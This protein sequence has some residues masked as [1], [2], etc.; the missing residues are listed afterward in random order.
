[1]KKKWYLSTFNPIRDLSIK[2]KFIILGLITLIPLL[3]LLW[4]N[5]QRLNAEIQ[6]NK[7]EREGIVYL[8]PIRDF[9]E[10][11]QAH[12]GMT[13]S[14]LSGDKSFAVKIDS[15]EQ[16]TDTLIGKI[17]QVNESLGAEFGT[18][19]NWGKIK[20]NWGNIK[21]QWL[22]LKSKSSL[23]TP[24]ESFKEHT[25][26]VNRLL[27]F[28]LQISDTSG[29]TLDPQ[30]D[31]YYVMDIVYL[32]SMNVIE[33]MA[34]IRGIGS[35]IASRNTVTPE[36]RM[37]LAVLSNQ[38]EASLKNFDHDMS[39]L[40]DFDG[41]YQKVNPVIDDLKHSILNLN[42]MVKTSIIDAKEIN[43]DASKYF[44]EA[45]KSIALGYKS[46]DELS[47]L[48][49]NL[50][51]DRLQAQ[52]YQL[53]KVLGLTIL[54]IIVVSCFLILIASHITNA[55]SQVKE[56]MNDLAQGEF[57]DSQ[58]VTV[59]SKDEMGQVIR[60]IASL[61]STLKHLIQ[62]L[63]YVSTQHE[64]GDI[65]V[66]IDVSR[67][68]GGYA[69]VAAGVNRMVAGHLDMSKKALA[70]VK[71][72]G[73]GDLD[74]KI[75]Q[76]PGKKAFVNE[77]I[78]QVRTN[79][80]ALVDDASLLAQA[81]V[82]GKLSTRADAS[83]HQGDFRKIVQ[84]VNDT[85]D[86]VITPLNVAAKY[87]EDISK[88]NIPAKITATYHGDFNTLKNNLNQCIDAVNALVADANVLANAA[89]QGQLSTRAD[90]SQHQGDF[91]KIVE[92][93]NNTLDSVVGPL[94]VAAECVAR[95]SQGDIPENISAHYHGD[96]NNIKNNLNT[97][98]NA[99]NRLVIDANMLAEA[100][101]EGRVT[102]RADATQHQGDFR[103]VVEGVNATLETIVQPI[104]VVKEAVEAITTA[105]GEISSGNSDLSA[106]TEQQAASLEETAASMEELASTVKQ[107]AENA[108]QANQLAMAA[109][110]VA[111]KGGDVVGQVVTT[112]ANINDSARKIEDII[113][114]IDGIAF[115]TNILALNAAV[116]AA[117]AGEQGR[118]FAVVAGEVRNLAQRSASAAKEIKELITDSVQKTTEGTTQVEN[119]GKT[120]DEIVNSVKRV[121]D[122]IG[123][124]AAASIEQSSGIDQV[125]TAVTNMD[126]V[127]QQNAALV[128]EAA[129]AA[130][131]LLEQ[132]NSLSETVSVFKLG[133]ESG[134]RGH[135]TSHSTHHHTSHTT[136]ERR[137][138]NS[139]LR[140]KTA[141]KA[142]AAPAPQAQATFAK[143][144]T[145][146][147]GDWEEF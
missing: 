101:S 55:A 28:M 52:K 144:G 95:I 132:A 27:E 33:N 16:K 147:A 75:E 53:Y 14:Y 76:F 106:R 22:Q 82:E 21:A 139:P 37:K 112:M 50:L 45:S 126:E 3:V 134:G 11:V 23:L 44:A 96:F 39:V 80:N 107:N 81:A 26:L 103:K 63:N 136:T 36:E 135:K 29:L 90:A 99:V 10:N 73:E 116:E 19:E 143:T 59:Y 9:I 60:S 146:D 140:G 104:T 117:R 5:I 8:N 123:E 56:M 40:K 108:K 111:I 87:V 93:V 6:V 86:A 137:A 1:M 7:V 92:G 113:T 114:V 71:R 31:T 88:G 25:D 30:T 98:I 65:D 145:D 34:K 62:S 61:E 97:C 70:C 142:K 78:E 54:T 83:R 35:G 13:N 79:I 110:D 100:A 41:I 64:A 69:D 115:Q 12:R 94:N 58:S 17:N 18:T 72:F 77:A 122:I 84:G 67:F 120:M 47:G 118:G 91:R 2:N 127:T 121:T 15:N 89:A 130:E 131:S 85:L 141:S 119:A 38:V 20:Q 66:D 109:S 138:S 125:N 105:A 129:A 46:Y 32:R 57:K 51:A 74:A 43:L 42:E 48:L 102:V 4:T 49:D 128:E 24:Q 124:I 133:N 68:K